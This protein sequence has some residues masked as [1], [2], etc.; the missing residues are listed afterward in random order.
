MNVFDGISPKGFILDG[1][2]AGHG[3][4]RGR[5]GSVSEALPCHICCAEGHGRVPAYSSSAT[6]GHY[7]AVNPRDSSFLRLG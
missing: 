7:V 5:S 6:T 3:Q 1:L 4:Q 2:E